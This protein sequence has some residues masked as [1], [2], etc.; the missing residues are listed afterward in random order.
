MK[1]YII[2]II[3]IVVIST[4]IDAQQFKHG[5]K[6]G[7]EQRNK[8][9]QLEKLKLIELLNLDEET[10]IRFFARRNEHMENQRK[11]IDKREEIFKEIENLI[12]QDEKENSDKIFKKK[13][14]EVLKIERDMVDERVRFF[15]KLDDILTTEQ[16]AAA[17]AFEMRFRQEI[18][19]ILMKGPRSMRPGN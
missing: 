16:I 15:N 17:L 14:T 8:I 3:S 13:I 10:S 7:W 4:S 18:K 2:F 1:A 6:Y 11:F 5:P 12:Q 19:N 9:E